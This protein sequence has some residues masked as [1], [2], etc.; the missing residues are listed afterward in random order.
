MQG[1][2]SVTAR[3]PKSLEDSV[4]K[5]RVYAGFFDE[6]PERND[7]GTLHVVYIGGEY[8]TESAQV[9]LTSEDVLKLAPWLAK[10]A[11]YIKRR[12]AAKVRTK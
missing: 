5:T 10:A 12:R 4:F 7:Q 11:A 9:H 6:A 8:C 2:K 1:D 3:K